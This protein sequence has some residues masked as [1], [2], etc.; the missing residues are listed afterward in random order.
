MLSKMSVLCDTFPR[1]TKSNDYIPQRGKPTDQSLDTSKVQ[2]GEPMIF[3]GFTFYWGRGYLYE[4]NDPKTSVSQMSTSPWITIME[5]W[6]L[7]THCTAFIQ[8]DRLEG[9]SFW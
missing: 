7:G 8:V 9:V 5:S 3:I 6:L 1:E 4:Q 2:L